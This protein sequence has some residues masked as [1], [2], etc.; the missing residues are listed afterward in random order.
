MHASLREQ[1]RLSDLEVDV[2]GEGLVLVAQ[3]H[4]AGLYAVVD[5]VLQAA[6]EGRRVGFARK[7]ELECCVPACACMRVRV[8]KE[9]AGGFS[10]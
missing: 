3:Q 9:G 10:R 7:V 4:P 2:T 5:L 1:A 6:V 8:C